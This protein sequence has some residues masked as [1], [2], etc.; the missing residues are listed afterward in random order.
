MRLG[1]KIS[2]SKANLILTQL[3]PPVIVFSNMST[4]SF[5]VG[6]AII[7]RNISL[8]IQLLSVLAELHFLGLKL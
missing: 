4:A 8:S 6:S 3:K 1:S 7:T 2:A 5:E